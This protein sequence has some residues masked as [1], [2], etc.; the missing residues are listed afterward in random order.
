MINCVVIVPKFM[1]HKQNKIRKKLKT[2]SNR[3][4]TSYITY[5]TYTLMPLWHI[6]ITNQTFL[7]RVKRQRKA[8][9]RKRQTDK[10]L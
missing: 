10:L 6:T 7:D 1:R 4:H 8:G 3:I 5:S 9:L 2:R